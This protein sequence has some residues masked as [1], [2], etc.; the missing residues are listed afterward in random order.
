MMAV[1]EGRAWL[2]ADGDNI[3]LDAGDVAIIRGPERYLVA[4]QPGREASIVIHPG[5][6]CTT[7]AGEPVHLSLGHG[8]R[9][10]GNAASGETTM[11]IGTYESDA[12]IGSVVAAALPRTAVVR[13]GAVNPAL[14]QFLAGEIATD[15]PG[16]GSVIDRML[17]VLLVHSVRA[18]AAS[19]PDRA[20]GWLSAARDPL[21]GQAL[22]LIHDHPAKPWTLQ[23]LSGQLNVS[24]ATL[25]ARFRSSVGE[26]PMAY[27]TNWRMLLASELLADPRLTTARIAGEV[28]Y[29]SA[30][31]LSTAFKRRYGCSPTEYRRRTYAFPT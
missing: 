18:W 8:V 17:D 3:A 22:D 11:L 16:Q 19:H 2:V 27:L 30:F 14:I 24:R 5:Q 20:T 6:E 26:P 7:L 13:A 1:L 29:G 9:T 15:A 21:V 25:A 10:W 4:D 12:T 23:S 28:G 31:A